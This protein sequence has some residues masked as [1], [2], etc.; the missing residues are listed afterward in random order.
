[1]SLFARKN[2]SDP[3]SL[4]LINEASNRTRYAESFRTLRTNI[5]F[6]L[7]DQGF[8]SLLVT[9]A[10]TGEGKTNTVANLAYTM[11]QAGKSVLMVDCDLR[12]PTLSA[13]YEANSAT[14]ISGLL[15]NIFN[16]PIHDLYQRPHSLFDILRFIGF[17]KSTGRLLVQDGQDQ[18]ELYFI[19]GRLMD[20]NWTTR[21]SKKK[22]AAV[23]V[24]NKHLSV[25]QAKRA[26][27]QQKDTGNRLG[28]IV[29]KMGFVA[30]PEIKSILNIQVME[31]L[32]MMMEM[33][34]SSFTFT[35]L[36]AAEI[37]TSTA[38]LLDLEDILHQAV[39][40]N[41]KLPLID[42]L[43]VEAVQQVDENLFLLPTGAIPSNPSELLS[44]NRLHFLF[45]RLQA[46]YDVLVIDSPPILPA[47]DALI[48]APTT[49]GVIL[50][51][52]AGLLHR[53]MLKKAIEQL[54][55][56]KANLL[57]VVLNAVDTKKEGYYKN[58]YKYYS[59]YYGEK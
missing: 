21:P 26:L 14:G 35:D 24:E 57:G 20:L 16:K 42:S 19:R 49:D 51:V 39:T 58:Y 4:P 5:H 54:R 17:Q 31:A 27:R 7:V 13:M 33:Q 12:R 28:Y 55:T 59:K 43:I 9:S 46:M 2:Q 30:D 10:G 40:G 1:M 34:L 41:E 47:S 36:A 29:S 32:H 3:A 11:A 53:D 52:K 44:S 23:L 50:V 45:E 15:V 8:R 22:L 56:S 18:V 38:E 6:S 48:L 37:N 25:E